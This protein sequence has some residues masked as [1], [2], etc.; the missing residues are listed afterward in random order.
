MTFPAS[1]VKWAGQSDINRANAF[2]NIDRSQ[3][4]SREFEAGGKYFPANETFNQ[5][6]AEVTALYTTIRVTGFPEY[7]SAI[8]YRKDS[9]CQASGR[10]YMSLR[11]SNKGHPPQTSPTW[12]RLL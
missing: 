11:G 2:R 6:L 9:I 7:D 12:W 5:L 4:W 1:M 3:G 10:P 8:T